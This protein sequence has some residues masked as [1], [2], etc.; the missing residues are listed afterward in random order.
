MHI[1]TPMRAQNPSSPFTSTFAS[2]ALALAIALAST[3]ALTACNEETTEGEDEIDAI[4]ATRLVFA[5]TPES[6]DYDL[7][8]AIAPPTAAPLDDRPTILAVRSPVFIQPDQVVIIALDTDASVT[9]D[10][11]L[12]FTVPTSLA[13]ARISLGELSPTTNDDGTTTW[14]LLIRM[15]PIW[16]LSGEAEV[17]VALATQTDDGDLVSEYLPIQLSIDARADRCTLGCA[18]AECGDDNCGSVCGLCENGET[19]SLAGT[20]VTADD[21]TEAET[22]EDQT[23]EDQTA[24]DQT[25]ED[26]SEE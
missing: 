4:N 15:N 5:L 11:D 23:T 13:H 20:C 25:T 3:F 10:T 1:K 8:E 16:D 24:E 17:W 18:G 26:Q 21:E 22:A 14:R 9:T 7:V 6:S 12:L 19:C 2:T